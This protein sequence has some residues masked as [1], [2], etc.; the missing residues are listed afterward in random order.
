MFYDGG[1]SSWQSQETE[2]NETGALL[3]VSPRVPIPAQ[4]GLFRV[5]IWRRSKKQPFGIQFSSSKGLIDIAEDLPHLGLQQFDH[6]VSLNGKRVTTVA[7]CMD[8]LRD[9][10]LVD[11]VL[12][13]IKFDPEIWSNVTTSAEALPV[14]LETVLSASQSQIPGADYKEFQIAIER[15]SIKQRLGL[16]FSAKKQVGGLSITIAEDQPHLG[17]QA[18]DQL[19]SVNGVMAQSTEECQRV[20]ERSMMVTL[21]LKRGQ[22]DA[23]AT[24]QGS[25]S[26]G[27]GSRSTGL[28]PRSRYPELK[29]HFAILNLPETDSHATIRQQY[30]H[31]ARVWHPDKNQDK[32]EEA[33]A[34]FQ[35]INSAYEAIRSRLQF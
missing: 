16:S 21:R 10:T 11:M 7:E 4:T 1:S 26:T 24:G 12:D 19:I 23:G 2:D 31:L 22:E 17:L 18:G 27:L 30:I 3:K 15:K 13:P 5:L 28:A 33:K 9:A 20:L 8:V 6:V 35:A 32:L 29:K 25:R 14:D 34:K